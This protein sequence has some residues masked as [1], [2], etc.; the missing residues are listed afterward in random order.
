MRFVFASALAAAA[1]ATGA[2]AAPVAAPAPVA[3]VRAIPLDLAHEAANA[4]LE[5]CR[6]Q[7]AH[8]TV[9]IMDPFGQLKFFMVDDG[10]TLIGQKAVMKTMYLALMLPASTMATY[11]RN[12][13]AD[14]REIG[15][16][17]GVF[18]RI[19]PGKALNQPGAIPITV[20]APGAAP[21]A[22]PRKVV[23]GAIGVSGATTYEMNDACAKAGI[24]KIQ[25]RLK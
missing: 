13:V 8:P 20:D 4:A 25:D 2:A 17:A 12:E 3:F 22:P 14:A 19:A 18:E 6:A 10:A 23:V 1:L 9:G 16:S 7:G 24:A 11:T 15:P 5:A 21:G